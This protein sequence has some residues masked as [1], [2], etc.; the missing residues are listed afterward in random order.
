MSQTIPPSFAN[1]PIFP[2]DKNQLFNLAQSYGTP[3]YVYD[4]STL[5]QKLEQLKQSFQTLPVHWLYAMKANDNPHILRHIASFGFGFDTVSSEEMALGLHFVEPEQIFYTEN[6]M[7]DDEMYDAMKAGVRLNIGSFSRLKAFAENGGQAC[8]IRIVPAIGDGL[9]QRVTTGHVESK[10][11]IAAELVPQILQLEA[12]TS[13][14]IEGVHMHIGSGIQ[15]ADNMLQAMQRIIDRSKPFKQLSFINFGGGFPI[16]YQEEQDFFD[17]KDFAQRA[18]QLLVSDLK[19]RKQDF[20]YYFEPGRWIIGQSGCLLTRISAI[21]QAGSKT[22]IGC[23]TGF[24]H[25]ARPVLYD[26]AHRV[27][28]LHVEGNTTATYDLA[29][30]ICESSDILAQNVQLTPQKEGDILAIAD[31]GAYGMTMASVYN[32]RRMPAEVLLDEQK[33]PI[34]IRKRISLEKHIA[35]FL[36][37]TLFDPQTLSS[38]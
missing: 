18:N 29:G 32:R 10:F 19:A 9:H 22:Y 4:L 7:S 8:S 16:A 6:N 5:T 20:R 37:E 14:R 26:A 33:K 34:L 3:L 36:E 27:I 11:G 12:S 13:L 25:L 17:F 2:F 31:T 30:N 38:K 28:A 23:D 1:Q 24:N 21:K 15:R 35:S